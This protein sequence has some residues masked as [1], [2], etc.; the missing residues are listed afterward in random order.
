MKNGYGFGEIVNNAISL[1]FTKL[2]YK[3]ARLIRRP[4]FIRGKNFFEYG[5]GFTTG[6]NCRIEMFNI[7]NT[8][9]KKLII[10]KNCKIGDYVHIAAGERVIIGDNCLLASKIYISDINHGDYSGNVEGS[11]PDIPPDSRPLCT[12]AVSIG[13]NV[14]IGENVC[15]LPG[16]NI[17][18]G[19]VIGANAVVNKDMPNSCIVVGC[20][21]KVIKRFNY[22]TAEWKKIKK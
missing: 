11:S 4:I 10:G 2:F 21:A 17:G 1:L 7:G 3:G 15:I 13:N 14:W 9:G 8:V 6:Y 19:C 22:V 18:D 20:P 16:V 12:K 5:E